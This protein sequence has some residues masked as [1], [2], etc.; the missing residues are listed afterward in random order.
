MNNP[1]NDNAPELT[2]EETFRGTYQGIVKAALLIAYDNGIVNREHP[3]DEFMATTMKVCDLVKYKP[4]LDAYNTFLYSLSEE[5]L[6]DVCCG[7]D[8]DMQRVLDRAPAGLDDFL[9]DIF[10][11]PEGIVA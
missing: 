4:N 2:A 7:E 1:V 8:T 3:E 5:E 11:P 10:E 9:N 6:T